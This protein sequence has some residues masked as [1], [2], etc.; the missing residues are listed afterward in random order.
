MERGSRRINVHLVSSTPNT[1]FV[2]QEEAVS[3]ISLKKVLQ[4]IDTWALA[5]NLKNKEIFNA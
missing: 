3:T 1:P 5:P 4:G 2:K